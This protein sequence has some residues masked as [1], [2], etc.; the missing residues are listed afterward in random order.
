MIY[1]R[2]LTPRLLEAFQDTPLLLIKGARQ[3]GKSTLMKEIVIQRGGQALSFDDPSLLSIAK[4][5]PRGFI[6][7]LQTPIL[8]DEVQRVPEI[9][10]PLKLRID[11]NQAPGQF[12]LTGSADFHTLPLIAD[13]MAGRIE[14]K[15]LWP[16]SQ[17][18]MQYKQERFIKMVFEGNWPPTFP[19]L[20]REDLYHRVIQGGY[21]KVTE[22][23]GSERRAMWFDSY[24]EA[25]IQKDIR[26]ISA[27]EGFESIPNLMTVLASR[28]ANLLNAA[29][30]SRILGLSQATVKR[31][32]SLLQSI[33]MTFKL[34]PWFANM[35][36]R[37]SK[38][39]K[40]YF[41]DS[42]LLSHI[43]RVPS[44][45]NVS[46]SSRFGQIL[47]NF[48]VCEILKQCSWEKE[49]ID[50]HHFR[51]QSGDEVDLVLQNRQGQFVGVEIKAT[52]TVLAKDFKGLKTFRDLTK[53]KFSRGI[54]LYTGDT[55]IPFEENLWAIPIQALWD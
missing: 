12:F 36:K 39:P 14:I 32:I 49:K 48:A 26:E 47:E 42:G 5:D 24:L 30:V 29:D 53:E 37:L 38:T 52:S 13:S 46:E 4:S 50:T 54:I 43:L 17:G 10:L 44:E 28:S 33:F 23:K 19:P 3:V 35:D 11:Q 6:D 21:P 15:T 27:I 45:W 7:Q 41:Y 9:I 31:Y 34:R 55:V 1:P 8:L 20:T 40:I 18:E 51:T 2:F 25:I 16:L 22:R